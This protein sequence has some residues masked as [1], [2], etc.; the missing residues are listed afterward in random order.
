MY[1]T[2]AV[3]Y[4]ISVLQMLYSGARPFWME[5]SVLSSS[6]LS[7][8]N[9]PSIG[10]ILM[11]FLPMYIYY[12]AKKKIGK[13]FMGTIPQKHLILGTIILL[14]TLFVN[15]LNYFLGLMYIINIL[16]SLIFVVLL[17]MSLVAANSLLESLLKKSTILKTDAKKYVFY[18]L[19]LICLLETFVL[20]VYSGQ[21]LFLDIDWVQNYMKCTVNL[22]YPKK[23]YRFDEVVG[24]WFN[25][26]QTATVF[27]WIGGIFGISACFRRI[28]S[29]EWYGGSVKQRIYR[30]II[31]NLF[32][33]PSWLFSLLLVEKGEWIKDIGLNMF[34]VDGIHYFVLYLWIFGY[35]PIYVLHKGLKI[36]HK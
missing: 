11:L 25:F 8:Y 30:L 17:F 18:W 2:M 22:D 27:G 1:V 24:P 19:L 26:V 9:H 5:E 36:T 28:E 15:F 33:V 16:M 10:M 6:C 29:F 12:C 31:T 34:I 23:N 21:D 20:I 35:M 14:L 4:L 13:A 7:S 32:I 3:I